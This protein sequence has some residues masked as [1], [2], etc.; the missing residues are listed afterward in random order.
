M[1]RDEPLRLGEHTFGS[2]LIVGTGKF[3][4]AAVMADAVFY[5]WREIEANYDYLAF[6]ISHD[7]VAFQELARWSDVDKSW[8]RQ[9]VDFNEYVG[10]NSVWV[11]W[12]FYSDS[13]VTRDGPWV[14]DITIWKYIP[15]Q[16]TARG[17]FHHYNRNDQ[18][19]PA[20]FTKVYLYDD[21]GNPGPDGSDDLLAVTTTDGNGEFQFPA[22]RNWD[23]DDSSSSTYGRRLDLYVV[24]ET[25]VW[26]SQVARE[27][28]QLW[29]LGLPLADR[30]H[31]HERFRWIH[32]LLWLYYPKR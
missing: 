15:G 31:P 9:D 5:L 11:A 12:R 29:R 18:W 32:R 8:T 1:E 13:T 7:G 30:R 28:D 14:D 10:D 26:D 2:R 25:D 23:V 4:S 6:E 21:D 20:R 17:S 24:W 16:V 3:S 19:V 22:L 27:G